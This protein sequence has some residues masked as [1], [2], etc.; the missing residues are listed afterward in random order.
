MFIGEDGLKRIVERTLA[1][2]REHDTDA[3][4]TH[5]AIPLATIQRYL[6]FWAPRIYDLFG[7][8][9]SAR[10]AEAYDA[11]I[12]GRAHEASHA[13]HRALA[14][15]IE[16]ERKS[17]AGWTRMH[18]PE[19]VALNA[20]MRHSYLKEVN[21]LLARLNRPIERAGA[22]TR[23]ALPSVRFN[24]RFGVYAGECFTPAGEPLAAADWQTRRDEWLPSAADRALLEA[25]MQ[26]VLERGRIAGWIAAPA[27]GI[28]NRPALDFEYVRL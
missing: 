23:L 6:N 15:P 27:R 2:M 19:R 3:V 9:E 25:L 21:A 8:D 5:G 20:A 18:V 26:P 10:A 11:G 24:R 1:L 4:G 17:A 16:I 13:D 7:N 14:E 28:D 12:K 22:S